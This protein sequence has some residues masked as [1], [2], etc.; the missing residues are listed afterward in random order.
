[1]NLPTILGTDDRIRIL[2]AVLASETSTHSGNA[3]LIRVQAIAMRAK[4]SKGLVSR[5][6]VILQKEGVLRRSGT[7]YVLIN[8][9]E[10]KAVRILLS[11]NNLAR[12]PFR[13][14]P[15]ITA[16]GLY[17]SAAKGTNT[18]SSDIDLWIRTTTTDLTTLSTI[19][20][21]MHRTLGPVTPL[22]LTDEKLEMLKTSDPM[23]YHALYF[24][25][26]VIYGDGLDAS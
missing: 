13:N 25:S 9:P 16:V 12:F 15:A 3:A 14:Y 23:F 21:D 22:Y 6:L 10:T 7:A 18:A 5:Y 19:T 8:G 1:M 26:I 17:G 20:G 4:V 11:L 2:A 24:G